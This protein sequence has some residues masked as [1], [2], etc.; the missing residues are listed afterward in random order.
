LAASA[1]GLDAVAASAFGPGFG[2]SVWA[3]VKTSEVDDFL[4]AWARHYHETFPERTEN[5]CFFATGAGPAAF[6]VC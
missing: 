5:A 3:M 1:R 6:R 2:G 4:A